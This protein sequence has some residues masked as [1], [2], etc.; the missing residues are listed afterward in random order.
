MVQRRTASNG[1]CVHGIQSIGIAPLHICI[2]TQRPSRGQALTQGEVAQ[3]TPVNSPRMGESHVEGN[4]PS[5]QGESRVRIPHALPRIRA[6]RGPCIARSPERNSMQRA[7][8]IPRR[9]TGCNYQDAGL[10]IRRVPTAISCGNCESR[11]VLRFRLL[12]F[13]RK[14]AACC[15][16]KLGRRGFPSPW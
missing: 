6:S 4:T 14:S 13:T 3:S 5:F 1:E 16:R 15:S 12:I 11:S 9:L 8:S 2:L 7:G 10:T